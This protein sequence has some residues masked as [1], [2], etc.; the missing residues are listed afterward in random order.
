M[1]VPRSS[2]RLFFGVLR[3]SCA[4]LALLNAWLVLPY[5]QGSGAKMYNEEEPRHKLLLF[6]EN[7]LYFFLTLHLVVFLTFNI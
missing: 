6:W 7:I 5:V 3:A 4:W 1:E 2:C